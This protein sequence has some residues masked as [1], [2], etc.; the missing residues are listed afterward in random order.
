MMI[1]VIFPKILQQSSDAL[2]SEE[3]ELV[4]MGRCKTLY[5][6]DDEAKSTIFSIYNLFQLC[7]SNK[8]QLSL[9]NCKKSSEIRLFFTISN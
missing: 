8:V 9:V 5:F 1:M 7:F 4:S 2:L 3:I 6:L